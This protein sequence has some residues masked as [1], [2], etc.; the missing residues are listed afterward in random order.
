MKD[1]LHN[2]IINDFRILNGMHF[3]LPNIVQEKHVD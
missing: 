1:E 2:I 3:N